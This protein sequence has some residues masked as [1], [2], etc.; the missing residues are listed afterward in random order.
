[1][2]TH[3]RYQLWGTQITHAAPRPLTAHITLLFLTLL[4][5]AGC[6]PKPPTPSGPLPDEHLFDDELQHG[7][8]RDLDRLRTI[9]PRMV[10]VYQRA[11]DLSDSHQYAEALA[12]ARTVFQAVPSFSPALRRMCYATERLGAARR[13]EAI[14]YCRDALALER[15]EANYLALG[16][17]LTGEIAGDAELSELQEARQM[18]LQAMYEE[19]SGLLPQEALCRLGTMLITQDPP[20]ALRLLTPCSAALTR[21]APRSSRALYFSAINHLAHDNYTQAERIAD[22]WEQTGPPDPLLTHLRTLVELNRPPVVRWGMMAFKVLAPWALGLCAL[23]ALGLVLSK[24]TLRYAGKTAHHDK[25]TLAERVLLKSYRSLIVL[26]SIFYYLSLPIVLVISVVTGLVGLNLVWGTG[27]YVPTYMLLVFGSMILGSLATAIQ[28]LGRKKKEHPPGDPVDKRDHPRLAKLLDEIEEKLNTRG[29]TKI[30][31]TPEVEAAVYEEGT[32]WQQFRGKST[33]CLILGAGLLQVLTL[34]ELRSILAHEYGHY[35]NKDTA[36]GHLAMSVRNSMLKT[37]ELLAKQGAGKLNPFWWF[38]VG[39]Y[40][41][42]MRISQGASRLQE[43]LADRVAARSY[44]SATFGKALHTTIEQAQRFTLAS[45]FV[46]E[47][48]LAGKHGISNLYHQAQDAFVDST[49][50]QKR[51]EKELNEEPSPYASHP[52][53]AQRIKLVNELQFASPKHPDDR[54]AWDVFRDWEEMQFLATDLFIA[55]HHARTGQNLSQPHVA[56][57][58]DQAWDNPNELQVRS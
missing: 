58:E 2:S 57:D 28:L 24:L 49:E 51:T 7:R 53:G 12:A 44:G 34:D 23:F 15:N 48:V 42:F 9:N 10:A 56:L 41:L 35:R 54:P 21:R 47:G 55:I 26:A 19:N 17:V 4:A 46:V 16:R 22:Q 6:R 52:S 30:F 39:Y 5:L 31:L 14:G 8:Q 20:A 1:M 40:Q 3:I 38:T 36:G 18:L 50:L 43:I 11:I 45:E 13:E 37:T 32:F 27:D 25:P 33:R 29:P